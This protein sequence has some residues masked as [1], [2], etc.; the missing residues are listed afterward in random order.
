[1]TTSCF[2]DDFE[3]CI[4]HLRLP[5]THRRAT[6]TTNLL[7]RLF[8]WKGRQTMGGE[9]CL[10]SKSDS[11]FEYA[12]QSKILADNEAALKVPKWFVCN[13]VIFFIGLPILLLGLGDLLKECIE[14][15]IR[16]RTLQARVWLLEFA[17]KGF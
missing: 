10:D 14:G 12:L 17:T 2:I 16:T 13:L 1:M 6:R 3:A 7:E 8:V 4:A 15:F 5:V 9:A 11:C